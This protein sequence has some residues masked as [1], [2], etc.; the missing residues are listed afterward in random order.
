MFSINDAEILLNFDSSN[1]STTFVDSSNRNRQVTRR[2]SNVII[3]TSQNK[4]GGSS[5]YFSG[6]TS[7]GTPNGLSFPIVYN[8]ESTDWTIEFWIRPNNYTSYQTIFSAWDDTNNSGWPTAGD[9]HCHLSSDGRIRFNN[10]QTA[11]LVSEGLS[12]NTWTH[13]AIVKQSDTITLFVDGITMSTVPSLSFRPITSFHVGYAVFAGAGD[14]FNGYLD[15]FYIINKAVYTYDFIPPTTPVATTATTTSYPNTTPVP[16]ISSCPECGKVNIP[17]GSK[18]NDNGLALKALHSNG[19][20]LLKLVHNNNYVID[21]GRSFVTTSAKQKFDSD[22]VGFEIYWGGGT[23]PSISKNVH[24][25]IYDFVTNEILGFKIV[26]RIDNNKI[27]I[28]S[29]IP[30]DNIDKKFAIKIKSLCDIETVP[31]CTNA[32]VSLL[33]SNSSKIVELPCIPE[34]TSTTTSTTSTTSTPSPAQYINFDSATSTPFDPGTYYETNGN[35]SASNPITGYI[36]GN[37][38]SQ[39]DKSVYYTC[40]VDGTLH[41]NL[42]VSSQIGSDYGYL[43]V[44]GL[45]YAQLT[46]TSS[47]GN[48]VVISAGMVIRLQYVKDAFGTSDLDRLTINSLYIVPT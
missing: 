11:G 10:S 14:S 20:K 33:P 34:A 22:I 46:G 15:N 29:Y 4:S 3:S 8:F 42:S 7:S 45:Q 31:C 27:F 30:Q 26:S 18:Y 13:I 28:E 19:E 24:F 41:Y 37:S 17:I 25:S 38:I 48:S 5:A 35:G 44:D 9:L 12:S 23:S 47:V 1:N 39:S 2:G 32:R 16:P 40:M 21:N 36:A 43:Y 6:N